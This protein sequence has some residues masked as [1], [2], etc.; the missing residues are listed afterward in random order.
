MRVWGQ[1]RRGAM[2]CGVVML[3]GG[4]PAWAA[5]PDQDRDQAA[6]ERQRDR[7]EAQQERERAQRDR[8]RDQRERIDE[9]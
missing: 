9:L 6:A 5:A 2:I 7:D 1:W 4:S 3:A 8:E